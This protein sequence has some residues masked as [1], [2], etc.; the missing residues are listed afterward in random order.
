MNGDKS[1]QFIVIKMIMPSGFGD[2]KKVFFDPANELYLLV[3]KRGLRFFNATFTYLLN[4]LG[5]WR[6]GKQV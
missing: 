5:A 1:L 4:L 3:L 6:N 2:R